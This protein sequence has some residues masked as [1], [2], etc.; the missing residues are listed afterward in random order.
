MSVCSK[1]ELLV[2]KAD[3]TNVVLCILTP[4]NINKWNFTRFDQGKTSVLK[5]SEEYPNMQFNLHE[6]VLRLNRDIIHMNAS[7]GI[8]TTFLHRAA[9]ISQPKK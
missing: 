2:G 9:I 1:Y 8:H 6:A 4:M 5:L 3:E 7:R